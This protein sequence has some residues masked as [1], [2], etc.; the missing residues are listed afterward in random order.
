[1][2]IIVEEEKKKFN[3]V[4][5]FTT[6]IILVAIGSAV[7]YLFFIN[8]EQVEIFISPE[9]RSLSDFEKINF[10]PNDLLEN[11]KFKSLRNYI[12]F[13]LPS[14]GAIG[15]TNPFSN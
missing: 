14:Q 1:M 13:A 2:A 4:L 5:I 3:W 9:L 8:P 10:K 12:E 6:L 15:K 7:F 11:T